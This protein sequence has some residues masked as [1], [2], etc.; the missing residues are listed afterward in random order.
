VAILAGVAAGERVV[1]AGQ[2][3]LSDGAPVSISN[4][5][6]GTHAPP[7]QRQER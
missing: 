1:T 6:A 2:M 5:A 3:K 4:A 7:A